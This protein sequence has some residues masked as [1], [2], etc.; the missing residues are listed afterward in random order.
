[1]LG[2]KVR[3][4]EKG[5]TPLSSLLSNKNLWKGQPCGREGSECYPC[6]QKTDVKE[7]CTQRNI[8]YESECG[9]CNVLGEHK[10]RDKDTLGDTRDPPSIYVGESAR[11]LAERSKEQWGDYQKLKPETHMHTNWKTMHEK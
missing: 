1:M 5:G 3:V 7:P 6:Q 10:V 8:L 9:K 4:S 11:S 2:F